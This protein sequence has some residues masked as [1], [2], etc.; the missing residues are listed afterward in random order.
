MLSRC[1]LLAI[2]TI[3]WL[4][5]GAAASPERTVPEQEPNDHLGIPQVLSATDGILRVEAAMGEVNADIPVE[6][7][8]FY[9]VF[10]RAGDVVTIAVENGRGG[11]QPVSL[12]IALFKPV[13]EA[14]ALREPGT[15]TS[16]VIERAATI[17]P[18]DPVIK[19]YVV[20]ESTD[21]VIGV[22]NYPRY[23]NNDGTVGNT[24]AVRNG[25]YHLVISGVSPSILQVPIA[26]KPGSTELAP[27]NP[28]AQGKL[29]VAILSTPGFSPLD[30]NITSLRFGA[31]GNEESLVSC[32]GDKGRNGP[33]GEDLN[34]DGIPDLVCHFDRP[35]CGFRLGDVEGILT[36]ST[37]ADVAFEGRGWLKIVPADR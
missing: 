18:A 31:T 9:Q 15:P 37:K 5:G 26:I 17:S 10:L 29:P 32:Q 19:S 7:L 8:D 33:K 1:S 16:Y 25:D 30:V 35:S 11:T 14:A 6:D 27:F 3:L 34:G 24:T 23:F 22:S 4:V 12:Y 28:K 20:T 36:G 2:G 21:Y 13:V